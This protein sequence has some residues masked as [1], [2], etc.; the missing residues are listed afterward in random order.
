MG[1]SSTVHGPTN[2]GTGVIGRRD[3]GTLR[4]AAQMFPRQM[5]YRA[6]LVLSSDVKRQAS[7]LPQPVRHAV[8]WCDLDRISLHGEAIREER[9]VPY[10]WALP[11]EWDERAERRPSILEPAPEGSFRADTHSTIRAMFINGTDPT[12]TPEYESYLRMV[13]AGS[14]PKGCATPED[15]DAYFADLKCTFRGM[16]ARGYLTQRQLTGDGSEQEVWVYVTRDGAL[17]HRKYGQH[18]IR[19]AELLGLQR[20]PIMIRRMHPLW[21]ERLCSE[22]D[23]P[24]HVAIGRWIASNFTFAT[25]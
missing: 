12:R 2:R 22:A 3:I 24:P 16:K 25:A 19:M 21:I 14:R 11:G 10:G 13:E 7:L 23:A 18:R 8:V 6:S 4:R 5:Q 9:R 20:A 1:M 15:V 17:C